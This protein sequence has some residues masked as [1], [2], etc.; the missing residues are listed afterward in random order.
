MLR[1]DPG[2]AASGSVLQKEL[3]ALQ[4]LIDA[5]ITAL[6]NAESEDASRVE[7]QGR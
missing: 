4:R 6:R 3:S 5:S 7:Q 2:A 1:R